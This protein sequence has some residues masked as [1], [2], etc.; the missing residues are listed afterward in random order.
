MDQESDGCT[1][2]PPVGS[3]LGVDVGFSLQ[4]RSS[5]VCRL[6]WDERQVSWTCQRFR[7]L[8]RDQEEA[9][10]A[11][12]GRKRLEAAAFDGP[13]REGFDVIGRYRVADR[14]LT[15]RLQPKIG[16]PGQA[17]APVGKR[18]NV[19][20]NDLVRITL[21]HCEIALARHAM[22]IDA[23]AVVEA[24]PTAFLGVMLRDPTA[25]T[26]SRSDRS[27]VFFQHLAANG[28]L[29]HL[30]THLLPGR[31]PTAPLAS[32][33]NH[34]DR[35]ALICALTALSVA[36]D[37]FTAVGDADGWIVLPPRPFVR[38]W[39]RADLEANAREMPGLACYY[40]G[41]R[42]APAGSRRTASA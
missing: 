22:R 24:F 20:T 29:E 12:S 33:T 2:L 42:Q 32:L 3:V 40:Q 34:D 19:A 35:A 8:P 26:V 1:V 11:V 31:S 4:R 15:R 37:D 10:A 21:K 7:A 39:A 18:L 6:D 16:K 23:R 17:S 27:D 38:S 41:R 28:A 30:I 25:I 36:A 13:V 5:A 9:S 14:M